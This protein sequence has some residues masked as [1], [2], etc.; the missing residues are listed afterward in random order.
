MLKGK[1]KNFKVL[2]KSLLIVPFL[3]LLLLLA[4]THDKERKSNLAELTPADSYHL[5]NQLVEDSK[6]DGNLLVTKKDQKIIGQ[7]YGYSDKDKTRPSDSDII[8][9]VA[10]IQKTF[11]ALLIA[12]LIEEGKLSYNSKL[13]DFRPDIARSNNVTIRELLEHT[14]SYVMPETASQDILKTEEE[15][16]EYAKETTS[17]TGYHSFFYTN[18]NYT[19]LAAVIKQIDGGSYEESIK[20][21]IISPL[22]LKNTYF[23]DDL[24]PTASL[25]EEIQSDNSKAEIYSE[26]LM[27]TLLGAGNLY[28][29]VA[30]L[31]TYQEAIN[32]NLLVSQASFDDLT[33]PQTNP[34]YAGGYFLAGDG[35]LV[36]SGNISTSQLGSSG[37]VSMLY[38]NQE[39]DIVIAWLGNSLPTN[40]L[41]N[42]GK[43]IYQDIP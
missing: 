37:Y 19:Y 11:T 24:P 16:I 7:A 1:Q 4:F 5:I 29:S 38:G 31:A 14:S 22:G 6:I 10:S 2:K 36:V 15:Q 40:S 33:T 25:A 43:S 27:S 34:N 13:E 9:P 21:R 8:Y 35:S 17:Y 20:R 42:L 41:V 30:D 18:V 3:G 12:Q 32:H 23:W 39:K 28:M 26:E